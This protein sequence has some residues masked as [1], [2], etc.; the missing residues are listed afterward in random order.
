[1]MGNGQAGGAIPEQGGKQVFLSRQNM[2]LKEDSFELK[3]LNP[4]VSG[5]TSKRAPLP[6]S[7]SKEQLNQKLSDLEKTIAQ[8]S[9]AH[10]L[11]PETLRKIVK[12]TGSF[13]RSRYSRVQVCRESEQGS[14]AQSQRTQKSECTRQ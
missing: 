9:G 2:R 14:E 1:M 7:K 13:P 8:E 10:Q 3:R 11:G 6:S 4:E 5:R 12:F